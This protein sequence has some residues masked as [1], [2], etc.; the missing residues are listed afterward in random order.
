MRSKRIAGALSE[1]KAGKDQESPA[2]LA[3]RSSDTR[4]PV[5]LTFLD[6][7]RECSTPSS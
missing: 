7:W 3:A 2:A 5:G 1:V 6:C 4:R